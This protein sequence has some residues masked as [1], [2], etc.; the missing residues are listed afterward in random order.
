MSVAFQTSWLRRVRGLFSAQVKT[1]PAAPTAP[2]APRATPPGDN[3]VSDHWGQQYLALPANAYNWIQNGIVTAHLYSLISRGASNAHWLEWLLTDYFRDVRQFKRS[4]SICCG[5]AAHELALHQS[6]KVKFVCGFDIAEGAIA[7]AN[8]KFLDA[9][10]PQTAFQ[11]ELNDANRLDM[12]GRFDL[13]LSL[14][15]L[16]HVTEI[17]DLLDKMASMLEPGGYFVINEFVGPNRFQWTPR[18]CEIVNAVL[19]SLDPY[20]LRA[21]IRPEFVPT[22]VEEMLRI[23]PSEAVRGEDI[24]P[25]VGERFQVEYQAQFNGTLMHVLYP[26]LNAGLANQGNRDFDSIVRLVLSFEDV[27]IRTGVLP[28]DFTFMICRPKGHASAKPVDVAGPSVT[29]APQTPRF[30][31]CLDAC[32]PTAVT[33][34]A[35]DTHRPNSTPFVD[36]HL[37]GKRLAKV[38]CDGFRGDVRAA[39]FGNGLGGFSYRFPPSACPPAGGRV[40]VFISGTDT[41]IGAGAI[42]AAD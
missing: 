31:G 15:A 8:K 11:F 4:L 6:K 29:A 38:F 37:D 24:V 30:V 12:R 39:G 13:L 42:P 22:P 18:Q 16:H 14:G 41:L 28:S 27:L 5:D 23:D 19:A 20:Y 1:R 7:L 35:V 36:V 33:G 32:S 3:R 26:L 2:A 40:E 25:L 9:G 34:W 17:E 10:V 21:G